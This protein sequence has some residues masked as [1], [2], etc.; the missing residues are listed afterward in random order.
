MKKIFVILTAGLFA[1]TACQEHEPETGMVLDSP[2]NIICTEST[3]NSLAFSWDAV[4]GAEQYAVRLV[5]AENEKSVELKYETG[6]AAEFTG[7]DSGVSYVC[8]VRAISGMDYSP[9]ASSAPVTTGE[10]VPGPDDPQPDDP[11]AGDAYAAMKIPQSEDEHKEA[12]AFPGAE[13]GGMYTTGGRGGKVI[14]VTNLN[15]SGAGSL[16]AAIEESGPRT[17]V[18]DVAGRIHLQ[19]ELRIRN[20]NLTIAGQTAPGDGICLSGQT[21]RVDADN[22][23]IRFMRF[24]LGYDGD[25]GADG[26]DA[27]WGRYHDDIIIDHCSMSWSVDEVGSFYANRNFTLQWCLLS[28]ALCESGHS[29]GSHG[30]GGIWGGRNASFHHNLLAHNN[31]RNARIDHPQIYVQVDDQGNVTKD[32]RESHRGHVDYRNNVIYNW[33]DNSTYGG[34]NGYFNIVGNYYKPGPASEG[35][36]RRYFVDAYRDYEKDGVIY[37][38]KYP[39]LYLEGNYHTLGIDKGKYPD[40]VY[41]HHGGSGTLLSAPLSIKADDTHTCWTTTHPVQSAYTAVTGYAG[42]SIVRDDVDERVTGNV[43]D[44]DYTYE[45]SNGSTGG[46]IDSQN[47][48]GGWPEYSADTDNEANGKTDTDGDGIPDW[49]EEKFGLDTAADD[50]DGM[51]IDIHGRYTN[52]E[53]YLHYLVRDIV[54]AQTEGGTYTSLG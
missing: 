41:W 15:D 18:F 51:D 2:Q 21:V 42:A 45:G 6:T 43:L 24:R 47:D 4:S 1:V 23:I 28:E 52:L 3:E 29:K 32:Y 46:I 16:R 11:D 48:V 19:S 12:L 50:A 30:Y 27:I 7:L 36:E 35:K 53:M 40:D 14:H 34:E 44:G 49:F 17:I 22:V 38:D 10:P 31:S 26:E 9:F 8:M 54:A 37:G 33:G 20:G 39:E 25:P 13:G 5:T